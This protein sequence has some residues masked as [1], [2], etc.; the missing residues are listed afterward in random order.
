MGN[1]CDQVFSQC[2]IG[3]GW[4]EKKLRVGIKYIIDKIYT[5]RRSEKRPKKSYGVL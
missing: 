5:V 3:D 1:T 2:R 4:T